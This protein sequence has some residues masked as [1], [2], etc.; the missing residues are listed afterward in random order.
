[1]TVSCVESKGGIE[2]VPLFLSSFFG[3]CFCLAHLVANVPDNLLFTLRYAYLR[4]ESVVRVSASQSVELDQASLLNHTIN[5]NTR[6]AEAVKMT[7]SHFQNM[8]FAL[9]PIGSY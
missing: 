2:L 8:I 5:F 4:S 9:L 3:I 6:T 7:V 1:M